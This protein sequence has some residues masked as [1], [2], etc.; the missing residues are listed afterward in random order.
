MIE[1]RATAVTIEQEPNRA[2]AISLVRATT[3]AVD[4]VGVWAGDTAQQFGVLV[5]VLMGPAVFSVYAFA[6]WALAGNLGWSDSFVFAS[7]PLS[8]WIIWIGAAILIHAAATILKK[9]TRV[10]TRS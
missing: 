1:P 10:E 8:N 4:R 6:V 3:L 7:G 2:G 9:H 5:A